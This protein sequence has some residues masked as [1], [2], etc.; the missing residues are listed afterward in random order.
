MKT[1][2]RLWL[3]VC[4]A[5]TLTC[6]GWESSRTAFA[7]CTKGCFETSNGCMDNITYRFYNGATAS[8]TYWDPNS[9]G[10]P[11]Q[12]G[13][14]QSRH[15]YEWQDCNSCTCT[16]CTE[17]QYPCKGSHDGGMLVDLSNVNVT[18]Q[19]VSGS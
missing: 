7:V 16:Y 15:K 12:A 8:G 19:C 17:V 14:L 9:L 1:K 5:A 18:T 3:L 6:A 13:N 11:Y 4:V 10:A 2:M